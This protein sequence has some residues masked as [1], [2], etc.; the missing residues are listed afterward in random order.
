MPLPPYY[1][2]KLHCTNEVCKDNFQRVY[3]G[4]AASGEP[5]WR[6]VCWSC[7]KVYG[8]H[9]ERVLRAEGIW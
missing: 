5:L 4:C 1:Y 3:W 2:T 8:Q 7:G 9:T 6:V